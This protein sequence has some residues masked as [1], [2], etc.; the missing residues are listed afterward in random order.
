VHGRIEIGSRRR[1]FNVAFNFAGTRFAVIRPVLSPEFLNGN[2]AALTRAQGMCPTLGALPASMRVAVAGNHV[3]L[4][5]RTADDEWQS[6]DA[7]WP[8]SGLSWLHTD[9]VADA[10]QVV[11]V[12][13]GLGYGLVAR[14]GVKRVI[15][16]E[17]HPGVATLFL[18]MGDWRQWFDDGRLRLVTGPDYQ[19]AADVARL[20][21]GLGHIAVVSH[22]LRARWE[23]AVIARATSVAKRVAQ[24]AKANG[25]ARRRFAG[26]Y[27]LQ[28]LTNLTSIADEADVQALE[29]RFRGVPAVVVGAGP[30]LDQNSEQL[31][32]LQD[33]ALI[34]TADTALGPLVSRGVRPHVAVAVDSSEL[35][36]RHVT[37]VTGVQDVALAA[38]GSVHP[39]ALRHFAGRVFTFRVAN[40]EPWPWLRGARVV[41]SELKTWGSV[42]TSAFN[43]ARLVGC[44]PIVF[45]GADLAFTGMR[46]Y[47]RGTIYDA[48][49]QEWIDKGCTWEAL[50][51]EYFS[52]QPEMWRE[53]VQ[54]APTRTGPHL[55]SFRDWLVEQTAR[56][57]GR[58]INGTGAGILHGGR[59]ELASLAD[60]LTGAPPAGDLHREVRARHAEYMR[61]SGDAARIADVVR[62]AQN[63]ASL[64]PLDRWKQFAV[65][66]V[67]D[68]QILAAVQ[69]QLAA[70]VR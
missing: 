1:V 27:L 33:R 17:P 8:E 34:I 23:P 30:S 69:G 52:R 53:D 6:I 51:T 36:A 65:N 13:V 70:A 57:P 48:M 16:I 10:D 47:C 61:T 64:L 25:N 45:A 26:P 20:L 58:V 46:P 3:Q 12:G 4:E 56:G 5:V 49:W 41:R 19:G 28:T 62:S 24:N 63:D 38:E 35:N 44:D 11:A 7:P 55:V 21:D 67:T 31:R 50:M 37:T 14:S 2:L 66:T 54:G 60:A 15:A 59:I 42:L 29:G 9:G 68:D 39:S 22:P 18:S 40:H 32:T 43:L